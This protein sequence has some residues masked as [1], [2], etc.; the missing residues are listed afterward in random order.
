LLGDTFFKA[1]P[2]TRQIIFLRFK[3]RLARL[4]TAMFYVIFSKKLAQHTL[5]A[6]L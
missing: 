4:K 5:K 6:V 2:N 3:K 1:K